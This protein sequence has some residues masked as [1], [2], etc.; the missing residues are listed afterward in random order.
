MRYSDFVGVFLILLGL[1]AAAAGEPAVPPA[2]ADTAQVGAGRETITLKNGNVLS[3]EI[4]KEKS[5]SLVLDLGFTVL[6][7]PLDRVE[8]RVKAAE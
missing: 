6:T 3:G 8:K 2:E 4:L 7:V 5:D 1:S